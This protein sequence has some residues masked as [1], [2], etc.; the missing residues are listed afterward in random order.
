MLSCDCGSHLNTCVVFSRVVFGKLNRFP[1]SGSGC[2]KKEEEVKEEFID[3]ENLVPKETH[4]ITI[5]RWVRL[6]CLVPEGFY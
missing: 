6:G 3:K 1:R 4:S 5:K 2:D